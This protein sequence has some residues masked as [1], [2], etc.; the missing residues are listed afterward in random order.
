MNLVITVHRDELAKAIHDFLPMR[1]T[2]GALDEDKDR[3]WFEIEEVETMSFLPGHGLALTC[4]AEVHYPLVIGPS[5][6]TVTHLSLTVV[7]AIVKSPEGDVLAFRMEVGAIDVAY[8]PAFIDRMVAAEIN[9]S[10]VKYATTIAWNFSHTLT[11]HMA[12][13][14]RLTRVDSVAMASERGDVAVT[15]DS[16]ILT[17]VVSFV[18]GHED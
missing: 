4:R 3:I 6:F 18:F 13:P 17:L 16:I 5:T 7:P 2:L 15:G 14:M 12:L 8:L 1:L 10:L 9:E 11:R